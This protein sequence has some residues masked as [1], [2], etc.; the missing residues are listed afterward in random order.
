MAR[1]PPVVDCEKPKPHT[2]KE[3]IKLYKT[4]LVSLCRLGPC[5]VVKMFSK[6]WRQ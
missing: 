1:K 3:I 2:A 5:M 4:T 6:N